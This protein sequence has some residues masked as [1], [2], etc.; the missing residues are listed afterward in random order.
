MAVPNMGLPS[1]EL[2]APPWLQGLWQRT[3]CTPRVCTQKGTA[4]PFRPLCV[5]AG[6]CPRVLVW[7]EGLEGDGSVP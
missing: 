2:L 4:F 1:Q 3:D 5:P 6:S 7:G